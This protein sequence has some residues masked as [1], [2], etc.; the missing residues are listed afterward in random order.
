MKLEG[1]KMLMDKYSL[2]RI[3][4]RQSRYTPFVN[5]VA[6]SNGHT[7]IEDVMIRN[8]LFMP[9]AYTKKIVSVDT[10]QMLQLSISNYIVL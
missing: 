7:I 1:K 6:I 10:Y 5:Q 2:M 4:E 3:S 9:I 8:V